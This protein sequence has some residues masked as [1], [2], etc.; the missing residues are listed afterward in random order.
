MP[1]YL[2]AIALML[3]MIYI[4]G[5]ELNLISLILSLTLLQSW[6]SSYSLSL[7][8]PTWVISVLVFFYFTFPMILS[9]VKKY[10]LT[11]I[12]V[13]VFALSL[14]GVTQAILSSVLSSE[15]YK[16]FPIF[17]N[18]LINY[19][20]LSH[21]CSFLLGV[22]GG[23]WFNASKYAIRNIYQSIALAGS[24]AFLV[25]F[26]INNQFQIANYLGFKFA[27][28]SS[29]FA[30]LFLIFIISISMCQSK[31]AKILSAKPLVL[32]GEASYSL[33][34]LQMPIYIIYRYFFAG[35]LEL[36]L[37]SD[38][39][40]YLVFLILISIFCLIAFERPTYKFIR[41]SLPKLAEDHLPIAFTR[42]K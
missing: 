8:S 6:F 33:Y 16:D 5:K 1:V 7:N 42:T 21:F 39:Y 4:R 28:A 23:M 25:V 32:L 35:S 13:L 12:K 19:F 14:W 37:V 24:A 10:N 31:V 29:F 26:I 34:V 40:L 22:S 2:L 9:T 11:A 41:F 17:F 20:P 30:P 38:F 27:F 36:S 18:Y 15:M 3:L